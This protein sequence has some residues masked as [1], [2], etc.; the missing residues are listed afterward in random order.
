MGRT[1]V[2]HVWIKCELVAVCRSC[3]GQRRFAQSPRSDATLRVTVVDPSGA[4]IVGA[5]VDVRPSTPAGTAPSRCRPARAGTR[6]FNAARAGSLHDSRR[7]R[8]VRA[9]RRARRARS[10]RA[11]TGARSSWRSRSSPKPST[12]DA[13]RA[14]ARAIREATPSPRARPGAD[15]RTAG[16]PRRDGAGAEGHGRTRRGPARQRLSRRPAAAEGSD[17]ADSFPPQHVRRRHAR[18]GQR[19]RRHHDQARA[20]TTGAVDHQRGVP[21]VGAERAQRVRADQGRRAERALRVQPERTALEAAH[22]AGALGRR[23]RRLRHEDDRRG[24]AVRLL[25]RLDSQAEQRAQ[26]VRVASST[27]CRSPR[28][29]GPKLQ[30]NHTFT[31]NLGVGDFDLP[32]RGYSQTRTENRP[33]RVDVRVDSQVPVQR[34]FACSCDPTR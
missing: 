16:R 22:V 30:R 11:T 12:W 31:D 14:S 29:S 20:S 34:A 33:A 19:L 28:C 6:T 15:R 10:A 26:P 27:R 25:C 2:G 3:S 17:P 23:H 21:R 7:I 9:V 4:V 5:Q 32:E 18:A 24:A 13:T 1:A 8:R